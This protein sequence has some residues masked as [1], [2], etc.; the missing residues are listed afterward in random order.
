MSNGYA[1]ALLRIDVTDNTVLKEELSHDFVHNWVGGTCM[2]AK[3]VYDEVPISVNWNDSANRLVMATGGLTGTGGVGSGAFGVVTKG[4]MTNGFATSQANGFFS[5][6]LKFCGYDAIVLQGASEDWVYIYIDDEKVEIKS[7]AHLVGLDTYETQV[8]LLE[9]YGLTRTQLS[10]A[11]IGPGGE[12]LVRYACIV[13]DFGHVAAHNGVGAVLG[14]KKIKAIAVKRG[15]NKPA[16]FDAEALKENAQEMNRCSKEGIAGK[17]TFVHGTNVAIAGAE[18]GGVLPIKNITTHSFPEIAGFVPEVLRTS[19][20]YKKRPCWGC[21]WNHVGDLT[22]KEGPFKGFTT[23][24]PEFEA[25]GGM[26]SNLGIT[27]LTETMVICDYVDRMGI[28]VNE[29]SWTLA[30]VIECYERGFFTGKDTDELEMTWD[31]FRSVKAM[32]EKIAYRQGVGDFLAEGLMRV[33]TKTGGEAMDCA[34]FTYK[35]NSIRGHDHRAMWTELLDTCV[36]ST[37]TIEVVGGF[38]N[39]AQHGLPPIT[40]P[41]DWEQIARYNAGVSGRRVFEDSLGVC[42]F[43]CEDIN[44][45]VA[46]L[47]S[48]T[49]DSYTVEEVVKI[50]RKAMN[51]MRV[52]NIKSGITADLEKPSKKYQDRP[53]DGPASVACIG[54]VF[55]Q[56]RERYFTLMGWD[57]HTGVPLPETLKALDLEFLIEE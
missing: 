21:N 22:V 54:D 39:A 48:A 31:N 53:G 57:P 34:N 16:V 42:R 27:N 52:Y 40:N 55:M 9:E 11:C 20:D 25:L 36:S 41:F 18:K 26:G 8:R 24:E 10:V 15:K 30:W 47:N 50:G 6:F 1:G 13:S 35:G 45:S 33:A 4:A 28:D 2:G 12:N 56:M 14:S 51:L 7:A 17:G 46:A 19:N 43:M 29:T 49:G 3:I 44:Y 37:G 32:I 23:E 38:I 5:A